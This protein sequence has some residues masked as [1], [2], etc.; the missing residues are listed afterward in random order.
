MKKFLDTITYF[1]LYSITN[2]KPIYSF[3]I[4]TKPCVL[5]PDELVSLIFYLLCRF[6]EGGFSLQEHP[7]LTIT[8][9]R[10]GRQIQTISPFDKVADLLNQAL[11]NH[12]I[13]P[14]IDSFIQDLPVHSEANNFSCKRRSF[15]LPKCRR[16][17]TCMMEYLQ[18][19]D[20]PPYIRGHYCGSSDGI[21]IS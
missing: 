2:I 21:N 6:L 8:Y 13:D 3:I 19:S 1:I 12:F 15:L 10:H 7:D 11:L 9:A 5:A 17:L 16:G 14:G 20:D 4:L 18:C